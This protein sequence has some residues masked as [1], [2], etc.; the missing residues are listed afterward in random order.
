[1]NKIWRLNKMEVVEVSAS[2]YELEYILV[3]DNEYNSKIL[4]GLGAT[5]DDMKNMPVEEGLR[6]IS[7]FA[8]ELGIENLR[9]NKGFGFVNN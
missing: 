1:M 7:T 4:K 9:Y 5:K 6:D 3:E 8:F 2:N